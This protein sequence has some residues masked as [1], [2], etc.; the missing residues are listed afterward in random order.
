MD[1]ATV[2]EVTQLESPIA[3]DPASEE[4][5]GADGRSAVEWTRGAIRQTLGAIEP[6]RG[7]VLRARAPFPRPA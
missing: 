1:K 2:E 4:V 5:G 6:V 3:E 7:A